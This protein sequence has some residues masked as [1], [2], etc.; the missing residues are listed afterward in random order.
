MASV[1]SSALVIYSVLGG[2]FLAS[3]TLGLT[4]RCQSNSVVQVCIRL[5]R[6]I[7]PKGSGPPLEGQ[8]EGIAEALGEALIQAEAAPEPPARPERPG[9]LVGEEE[10]E[11][12]AEAEPTK[13][14]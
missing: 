11:A 7:F 10:V 12:E 14:L 13:A 4:N 9:A 6:L 3:E 5:C 8:I 2:L 1:D